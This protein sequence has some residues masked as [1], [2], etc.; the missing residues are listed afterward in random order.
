MDNTCYKAKHFE[1]LYINNFFFIIF[2]LNRC[3][4]HGRVKQSLLTNNEFVL[5]KK[6][7]LRT[8]VIT[9]TC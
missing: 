6:C 3:T 1:N 7:E 5:K 4:A 9:S 2:Q 8:I